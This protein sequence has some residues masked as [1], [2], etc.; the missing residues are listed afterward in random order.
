MRRV[1]V[2][3]DDLTISEVVAIILTD[4]KLAEVYTL[5]DCDNII[6]KIESLSPSIILMDNKIPSTGGIAATQTIKKHRVYKN[7]PVIYFTG[8]DDIISLAENAGADYTLAKPFT[9]SQLEE[10]INKAFASTNT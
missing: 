9:I 3:D 10:V 7:I 2:C 5:P 1:L 8:S 4:S 6:E